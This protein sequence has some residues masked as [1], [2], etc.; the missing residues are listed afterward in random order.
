MS[1]MNKVANRAGWLACSI[2]HL[3]RSRDCM[4]FGRWREYCSGDGGAQ[5]GFGKRSNEDNAALEKRFAGGIDRITRGRVGCPS[6]RRRVRRMFLVLADEHAHLF[7][8]LF[9]SFTFFPCS[10]RSASSSPR[11]GSYAVR[12]KLWVRVKDA[13][14]DLIILVLSPR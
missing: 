9:S 6:E 7:R 5:A 1:V 12:V 8:R 4:L 3:S 10:E 2:H 13:P 11:G 14:V